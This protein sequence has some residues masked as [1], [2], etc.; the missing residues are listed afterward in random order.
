MKCSFCEKDSVISLMVISGGTL[1]EKDF[2]D[3]HSRNIPQGDVKFHIEDEPKREDVFE[4][5]IN[6]NDIRNLTEKIISS[7]GDPL[8]RFEK[9]ISDNLK[10][11]I[12]SDQSIMDEVEK[13]KSYIEGKE[14]EESL[15]QKK[16][17]DAVKE[18]DFKTAAE[19]KKKIDELK[20]KIDDGEEDAKDNT[21]L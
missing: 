12:K 10:N 2:C 3:E 7:N 6:S 14:S 1:D 20:K 13:F 5:I 17:E 16:I 9:M 21:D 8:A 4:G 15:L 19:L 11:A 18:E